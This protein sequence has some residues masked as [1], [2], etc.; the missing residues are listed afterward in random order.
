VPA[1]TPGTPVRGLVVVGVDGSGRTRRLR[2]L[3]AQHGRSVTWLT[4]PP[5][6]PQRPE[7]HLAGAIREGT[8]VLVDDAH[9][10]P[11]HA[12][13]AVTE[14]ARNG[15]VLG[16]ARRPTLGS[17]ELAALDEAVAA[18][19]DVEL[20]GPLDLAGVTALVAEV[21]GRPCP[22]TTGALMLE[23]SAGLPG[24]AAALAGA[25]PDG[26]PASG[27]N[28]GP[29]PVRLLTR[30]QHRLAALPPVA[31]RAARVLA[32]RVDLPDAVLASACEV[33]G[34]EAG[35]A[36]RGLREAGLIDPG[37]ER[38]VPAVA[39]AVLAELHPVQR[40]QLYDDLAAALAAV[41]APAVE[42]AT[43]LRSADARGTRAAE[44]Y[45]DA[46]EY[47][48]FRAPVEALDWFR[49]ARAAGASGP[50][51]GAAEAAALIGVAD[52]T[53]AP[54]PD[55]P[56]A[57]SR[58]TDRSGTD[59]SE[60]RSP[61]AEPAGPRPEDPGAGA[62]MVLLAGAL[63]FAQGRAR[64]CADR[65][66]AAPAP[67]P[68]LAVPALV[69]VGDLAAAARSRA[70]PAPEPVRL[71]AEAALAAVDPARAVPLFVEAAEAAELHPTTVV[72]PDTPHALGGILAVAD[73]DLPT[74]VHLLDRGL[75]H[76]VNGPAA[77]RRHRL[78][79]A[80]ARMRAGQL[81]AAA[82]DLAAVAVRGRGDSP[83]PD[84]R[85]RFLRV[86]VAA[87][88]ARRSGDVAQL[89]RIWPEA[90][91][92]LA[93]RALDLFQLEA[94]E[95]L[96]VVAARLRRV[97][98]LAP[99]LAV[100]DATVAGLAPAPAWA[101]TLG[102][103]H[104]QVAIAGDDAEGARQAGER[105]TTAGARGPRQVAQSRAAEVW[106]SAMAGHVD[107]GEVLA[108][109]ESLATVG[110]PWEGSRLAGD[111]AIRVPDTAAARRLLE[112]ARELTPPEQ[113]P[114]RTAPDASAS[115]LS[116]REVEVA[117]LVL[118]GRTHREIGA[119]LY[120]APK[121]VE[122]HVAR[123]RTKLGATSRA[124]FIAAVQGLFASTAGSP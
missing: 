78:L 49:L 96:A 75:Q 100:L 103:L 77:A 67:G 6:P 121:T 34:A 64:R 109:A 40:R 28:A 48:R 115:G 93:R 82:A 98:R 37:G 62:R 14:A 52:P 1:M 119:Q 11:P 120:I 26:A 50:L 83:A 3:A 44:A 60:A 22:E 124:E 108:A 110:L 41:R 17:P 112:R 16:I 24:V 102:W 73:G 58:D 89:R 45:R 80:W 95:E 81:D 101:V 25:L 57:T 5:D 27:G 36:V 61:G 2:G 4:V 122:H 38:M 8:P 53:P 123:I 51:P 23:D 79:L 66:A 10:W 63:D 59:L 29:V 117:R 9:R 90:E 20:L 71:L 106:V 116:E 85:D 21:S 97:P 94:A 68:A 113:G 99:V 19:G 65:L 18:A 118:A 42:V 86:A 74:A 13:P 70:V 54:R 88:L 114:S 92:L 69:A 7:E 104:L 30:V 33:S 87:G 47:L 76:G 105:I 39:R 31:T 15:L 84:G 91:M 55:P 43:W 111:A 32:L 56:N 72:L 107:A 35:D 46:G 12:L